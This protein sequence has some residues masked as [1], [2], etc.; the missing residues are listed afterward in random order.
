VVFVRVADALHT[1]AQESAADSSPAAAA[2]APDLSAAASSASSIL[3]KRTRE[4]EPTVIAGLGGL[5]QKQGEGSGWDWVRVH[6]VSA[7]GSCNCVAF[8]RAIGGI[9]LSNWSSVSVYVH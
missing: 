4:E 6:R 1:R 5:R 7:A 8:W 2:E 9:Q 3:T